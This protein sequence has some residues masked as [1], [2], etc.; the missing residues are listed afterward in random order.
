[1][2]CLN[3]CQLVK[4]SRSKEEASSTRQ[5]WPLNVAGWATRRRGPIKQSDNIAGNTNQEWRSVRTEELGLWVEFTWIL[6]TEDL[7]PV[8]MSLTKNGVVYAY[9]TPC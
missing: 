1:M 2:L 8:R 5:C 3:R 4:I 9:T 6:S 7:D